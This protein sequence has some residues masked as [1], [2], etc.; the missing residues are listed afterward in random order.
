MSRSLAIIGGGLSGT[1]VTLN[2]LKV[3]QKTMRIV[4]FDRENSFGRG[5]AYTTPHSW[6]LLNVPAS[7]MSLY[8]DEPGHFLNWLHANDYNYKASDFVP[9]SLYGTY[10]V[11]E[12]QAM[13][14]NHPHIHIEYVP[15]AATAIEK[16]ETS[17][18]ITA[19]TTY[20]VDQVVY[21]PGNFAP[22]HP[23]T[24]HSDY[25]KHPHYFQNSFDPACLP[26]VLNSHNLLI[27]GSGLTMID[28]VLSL[29][30]SHY[31]GRITIISPHGYLPQSHHQPL[32]G[33]VDDYVDMSQILSPAKLLAIVNR[34]LKRA[35]REAKNPM[36][37]ID[38]IR[39][40]IQRCWINFTL[41]EKQQFLRHLRHKWGVARHRATPESLT[42][43]NTFRQ[44]DRLH[45]L[46]GRIYDIE[47]LS[48]GFQVTYKDENDRAQSLET[49]Y[50][51]NCTGPGSDYT[52]LDDAL[53]KDLLQKGLI[54]ADGIRYGLQAEADGTLAPGFYTLGPPLK[55]ILW[56]STAIPEIRVQAHYL[57]LKII[58]D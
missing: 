2:L 22:A 31:K 37:V 52:S 27:L 18:L 34:E 3:Q 48:G 1:L 53:V 44:N 6:H 47:V 40:H 17:F 57:A 10:A 46:K 16:Q 42:I 43:L 36:S 4:W 49:S 29:Y 14:A 8:P 15:H 25:I 9:R 33:V 5:L 24:N 20:A 55:G 45:I 30:H 26:T 13:T 19:D 11:A 39:P 12:L 50:I 54:S 51:I 38:R 56:E 35:T 21:A 28:M 58:Q 32:S 23:R 7:N 41:A